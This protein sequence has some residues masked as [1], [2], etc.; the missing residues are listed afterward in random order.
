MSYAIFWR[1]YLCMFFFKTNSD[2]SDS[3]DDNYSLAKIKMENSKTNSWVKNC[4]KH[5]DVTG[6]NVSINYINK[7]LEGCTMI[8]T[9][10]K[11]VETKI[12]LF[13]KKQDVVN[14]FLALHVHCFPREKNNRRVNIFFFDNRKCQAQKWVFKF[15]DSSFRR[16]VN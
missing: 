3:L 8:Y 14:I 7:F 9:T 1:P 15:P 11:P 16:D 10:V 5:A 4:L 13:S 12:I 2:W 6:E